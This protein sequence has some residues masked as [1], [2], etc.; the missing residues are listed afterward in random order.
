MCG[1][2]CCSSSILHTDPGRSPG[3]SI[4]PPRSCSAL[5]VSSHSLCFR[6]RWLKLPTT[7]RAAGTKQYGRLTLPTATKAA[8]YLLIPPKRTAVATQSRLQAPEDTAAM[9]SSEP[10]KFQAAMSTFVLGCE[11]SLGWR[12]VEMY[13]CTDIAQGKP[14]NHSHQST[15]HSS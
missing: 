8:S 2:P 12:T 11:Y 5:L 9:P 14:P 1:T 10:P 15:S 13:K 6:C 3:Q 4:L 7:S